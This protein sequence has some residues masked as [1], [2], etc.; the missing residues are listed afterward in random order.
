VTRTTRAFWQDVLDARFS[1]FT[2]PYTSVNLTAGMKFAGGRYAAAL[3]VTN[4]TN[5]TIQQHIFGDIVKRQIAGEFKL[6]LR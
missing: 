5:E 3:K 6:L 2:P 1:G 4:L